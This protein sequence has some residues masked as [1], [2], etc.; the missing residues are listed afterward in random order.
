MYI[1]PECEH[2]HLFPLTTTMSDDSDPDAGLTPDQL[3]YSYLFRQEWLVSFGIEA[4]LY[5]TLTFLTV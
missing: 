2:N 4:V 1:K 3:E 5:G